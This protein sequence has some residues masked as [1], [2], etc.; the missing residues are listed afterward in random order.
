MRDDTEREAL[1]LW[2]PSVLHSLS[3]EAVEHAFVELLLRELRWDTLTLQQ[4]QAFEALFKHHHVA[5]G[6]LRYAPS[7][8]DALPSGLSSF[9]PG[10]SKL[11][12]MRRVPQEDEQTRCAAVAE[13]AGMGCRP[14]A[15]ALRKL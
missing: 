14:A 5:R 7:A 13:R 8:S 12:R 15:D 3:A 1:L 6:G 4:Y 2:L 9:L 11:W 10:I